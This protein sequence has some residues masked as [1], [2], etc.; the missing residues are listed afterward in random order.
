MELRRFVDRDEIALLHV[1]LSVRHIASY[2]YTHE[3]IE[4][5]ASPDMDPQQW[6]YYMRE[7]RPFIVEV[8]GWIRRCPA[9]WI[10]RSLLYIRNLSQIGSRDTIDEYH[11]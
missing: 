6:G 11:S 2:Y 7:L 10:H 8:G 9:E 4:A 5:W 1:F 3:Q